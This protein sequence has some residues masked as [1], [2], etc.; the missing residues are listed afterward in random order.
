[1]VELKVTIITKNEHINTMREKNTKFCDASKIDM[2][3]LQ[4]WPL[5]QDL[6]ELSIVK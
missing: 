1:M 2:Q 4:G 6:F 5:L 3:L